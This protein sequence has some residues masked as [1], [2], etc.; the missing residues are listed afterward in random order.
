[1]EAWNT[2]AC[3]HAVVLWSLL[4]LEIRFIYCKK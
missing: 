2:S 1:M 3:M 4:M